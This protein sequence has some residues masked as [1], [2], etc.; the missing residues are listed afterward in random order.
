MKKLIALGFIV[1]SSTVFAQSKPNIA[2]SMPAAEFGFKWNSA[3]YDSTLLPGVTNKQEIGFQLGASAVFD[4]APSFGLKT[5][6]FYSERPIT[7]EVAGTTTKSK[8]TYFEVPAFFMFK[9]ED[10]A[11]VYVGP[12]LAMK[13]GTDNVTDAKSMVVPITFGAQFKFLPNMGANIF[14]ETVPSE[15]AKGVKSSR[16]VGVNLLIT[17]D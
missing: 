9:F 11:G 2:Y 3:D 5:G 14:F 7:S 15:L 8:I 12:S 16:A 6:L 1:L 17:L 10:Y 13:L 4:F